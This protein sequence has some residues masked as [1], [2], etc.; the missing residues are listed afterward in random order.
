MERPSSGDVAQTEAAE[1]GTKFPSGLARE[2]DTKDPAGIDDPFGR[3]IGNPPGEHAGLAR[4][5][6]GENGERGLR[7]ADGQPL[8]VVEVGQ[9]PL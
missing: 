9:Q 7:G 3:L 1:P 6:G 5:G 8:R 4:A 2:G